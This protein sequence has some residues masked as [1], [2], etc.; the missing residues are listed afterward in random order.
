MPDDKR[1]VGMV[2][3]GADQQFEIA[4]RHQEFI[5]FAQSL[6]D[7]AQKLERIKKTGESRITDSGS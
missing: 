2:F 1:L 4:L 3:A 6:W 7:M 5:R